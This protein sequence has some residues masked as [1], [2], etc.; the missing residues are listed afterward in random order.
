MV[1]FIL[2]MSTVFWLILVFAEVKLAV[3]AR[4]K[5]FA[6]AVTALLAVTIALF[7]PVI[8]ELADDTLALIAL[9][10]LACVAAFE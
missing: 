8:A 2:A 7:A 5:L 4:F 9:I 1:L 10:K 6:Y 3:I